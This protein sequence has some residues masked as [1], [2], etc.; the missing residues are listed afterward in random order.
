MI[1]RYVRLIFY[2]FGWVSKKIKKTGFPQPNPATKPGL[3]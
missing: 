1:S 2:I 3:H